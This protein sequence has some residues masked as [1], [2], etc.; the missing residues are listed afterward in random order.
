MFYMFVEISYES[1]GY[2][3]SAQEEDSRE[4]VGTAGYFEG[5]FRG[6]K[7]QNPDNEYL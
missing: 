1:N 2:H 3:E 7:K 4:I 6:N 5:L